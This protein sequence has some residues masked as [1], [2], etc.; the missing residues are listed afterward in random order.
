MPGAAPAD[1]ER[2]S[3][4]VQ[5]V[6]LSWHQSGV[7]T[8]G[9]GG[10]AAA[11]GIASRRSL[12]AVA[13]FIREA[14]MIAG[15]YTVWQLVGSLSKSGT[16]GA[17]ARGRWIERIEHDWHLP[18]EATI[19]RVV[20]SNGVVAQLA[21]VYYATMHFGGLFAFLIW[22]FTRHRDHY[23]PV[24]R[25]LALATLVCLII[26]FVPVAPPRLL[27]GFQDTA[28]RYGQS[29]YTGGYDSLSAMPSVHV[30][31]AGLIGWAVWRIG[32]GPWRWLGPAHTG[33]TVVVV[34]ATANHW[35]ADGIVAGAMVVAGHWAERGL[36]R[37]MARRRH[38]GRMDPG[39]Q[40]R[41]P[42]VME[43]TG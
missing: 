17:F 42:V 28:M 31:W 4:R 40:P 36:T 10:A 12:R 24:R 3:E 5:N 25:V 39:T 22:M 32:R 11:F 26:Q 6:A 27:P 21:N 16:T 19:Q 14:A 35:W 18:S 1:P 8:L 38:D 23:R 37:A 9:L 41:D 13:P 43:T 7:L 20:T 29:V 2:H 30:A 15:L 34:V 33:L